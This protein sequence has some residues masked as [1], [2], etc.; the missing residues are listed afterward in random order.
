MQRQQI[1]CIY[2][3]FVFSALHIL[4]FS[5]IP[6]SK[7]QA[8]MIYA[9]QGPTTAFNHRLSSSTP[10]TKNQRS[11]Q[12][13]NIDQ[14]C[15]PQAFMHP[16]SA[17]P[18]RKEKLLYVV[19]GQN[20]YPSPH[21]SPNANYQFQAA[22]HGGI[23]GNVTS[24][25]Y[26]GYGPTPNVVNLEAQPEFLISE[27]VAGRVRHRSNTFPVDTD[28]FKNLA[29]KHFQP[30]N[31]ANIARPASVGPTDTNPNQGLNHAFIPRD[32]YFLQAKAPCPSLNRHVQFEFEQPVRDTEG[33]ISVRNTEQAQNYQINNPVHEDLGGNFSTVYTSPKAT[34][35][36]RPQFQSNPTSY[37]SSMPKAG[38]ME[39]RHQNVS[40]HEDDSL[41]QD[42]SHQ[43]V[44]MSDLRSEPTFARE[45]VLSDQ[46]PVEAPAV[47]TRRWDPLEIRSRYAS[48]QYLIG[49]L[50]AIAGG[51]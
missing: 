34:G 12:H 26:H 23:I 13:Y 21:V 45:E 50:R 31:A 9:T 4:Y 7:A 14:N 44:V 19:G 48:I 3:L 38:M 2:N 30:T 46:V 16:N 1:H 17:E 51:E 22:P 33:Q 43:D 10:D 32:D 20:G 11:P 25:T 35:V 42:G 36:E 28:T 5:V 29:D 37:T 47:G 27:Q 24:P 39:T 40:P 41:L 6:T 49:Q 8:D 18:I 15:P